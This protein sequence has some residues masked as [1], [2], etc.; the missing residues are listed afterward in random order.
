MFYQYKM[1]RH[2]ELDHRRYKNK[3][4][5]EKRKDKLANVKVRDKIQTQNNTHSE[6]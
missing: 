3:D 5:A 2:D 4:L 1:M 6:L